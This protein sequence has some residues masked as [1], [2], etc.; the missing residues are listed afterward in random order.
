M[1]SEALRSAAA[2]PAPFA[3]RPCVLE[4]VAVLEAM[5]RRAPEQWFN[6]FDVWSA[7]PAS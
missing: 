5:I 2:A 4:W 1:T 6:F 3:L 7:T